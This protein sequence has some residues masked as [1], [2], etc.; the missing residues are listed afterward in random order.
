MSVPILTSVILLLQPLAITAGFLLPAT[1]L[2][3]VLSLTRYLSSGCHFPVT[4]LYLG[5]STCHRIV[6]CSFHCPATSVC[7]C[8]MT[9]ACPCLV[10]SASFLCLVVPQLIVTSACHCLI[11]SACHC[12]ISSACQC[13]ISSACQ[14]LI[15]ITFVC[16]CPVTSAYHVLS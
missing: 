3:S 10:T 6:T 4:S 1:T 11:T 16:L 12:L 5:I 14:C 13:L 8:L 9:A 2:L 7:L 15:S